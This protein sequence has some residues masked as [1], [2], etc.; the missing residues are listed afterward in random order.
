MLVDRMRSF[1][2]ISGE[3]PTI[4]IVPPRIAQNPIGISRR[5]SPIS[6]LAEILL[7]TGKKSAA[8]PTF[9]INEEMI[10]TVAPM[11]G[12]IRA[13]VAPPIFII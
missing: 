2:K 6:V 5:P 11:I 3:E 13:S 12:T 10:P 8:A 1:N 4:V 9:C 7:T